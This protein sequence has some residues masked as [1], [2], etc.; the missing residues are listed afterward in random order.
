MYCTLQR[1]EN[2]LV[3]S[4][5]SIACHDSSWEWFILA[6]FNYRHE[7]LTFKKCCFGIPGSPELGKV[8]RSFSSTFST[9]SERYFPLS[10]LRSVRKQYRREGSRILTCYTP[11]GFHNNNVIRK[12]QTCAYQLEEFLPGPVENNGK[13]LSLLTFGQTSEQTNR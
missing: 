9:F 13:Y 12:Q 7:I 11:Q 3:D 6:N 2:G 4:E 8:C 1:F 5:V 10:S